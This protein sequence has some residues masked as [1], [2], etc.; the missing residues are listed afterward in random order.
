MKLI[1]DKWNENPLIPIGVFLLVVWT[2]LR[3]IDIGIKNEDLRMVLNLMSITGIIYGSFLT[4]LGMNEL[5]IWKKEKRS[6]NY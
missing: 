4:L 3:L 5:R 2:I 1:N 6:G